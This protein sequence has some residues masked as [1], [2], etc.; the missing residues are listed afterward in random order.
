MALPWGEV[1]LSAPGRVAE[2][3]ELRKSPHGGRKRWC[4]FCGGR[5][6]APLKRAFYC[7]SGCGG[8]AYSAVDTAARVWGTDAAE[9]CR[10]LAGALGIACAD[11]DPP[12][13]A[14]AEHATA[15]VAAV[16]GL[17][18]SDGRWLWD[19]PVCGGEGTLRSYRK[20]WRCR[21]A[22]CAGDEQQGWR[23]HVDLGIAVWRTTP[24]DACFRMAAALAGAP[25]PAAPPPLPSPEEEPGPRERALAALR[26]RPGARLPEDF[27]RLLL[28]HLRLGPLGRAELLRRQ[29]EPARAEAFGFRS[30]EP[31]EW[32]RRIRPLMAAFSDDELLAA[33]FPRQAQVRASARG[34]GCPWWPGW[35]RAPLLVIP[36]WDG[37]R[38]SG[39]YFRNLGDPALTRC[40]RYV[41]PK[42]A[43]PDAPFN[44]AALERGARTLLVI[45]GY[46]NAYA[47]ADEPSPAAS[48][49]IPGAWT[50]Q[51]AWA[52]RISDS[53]R[54]V[55]GVFDADDAGRKGAARVRD[56]LARARGLQW[57]RPRW[58]TLL[59]GADFCELRQTRELAPILRQEPWTRQDVDS[60]WADVED[61]CPAI[62]AMEEG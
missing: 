44:G 3:L 56:S 4:P 5:N 13:R 36:A 53:T 26:G 17:R 14:V 51:D 35:G 1:N 42:D 45:E 32:E 31:G 12:W 58:R 52:L 11:A 9:A 23:G 29:I 50:W 25:P 54:Y 38:L 43:L 21:S 28:D 49:G 10:R 60:L 20:R 59:L 30:T 34:R 19:C 33:G 47:A 55:V 2:I 61:D 57:A 40:P 7:Y 39:V 24:A 15:E 18:S 62:P 8:K 27:Y 48:V 22:R 46:L 37:T 6:F 16:L 41:S